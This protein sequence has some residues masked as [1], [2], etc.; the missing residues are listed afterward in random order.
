MK[1]REETLPQ[2]AARADDRERADSFSR[3]RRF[4]LQIQSWK[5]PTWDAQEGGRE[6]EERGSRVRSFALN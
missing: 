2:R 3:Q 5:F 1:E 4:N 6:G